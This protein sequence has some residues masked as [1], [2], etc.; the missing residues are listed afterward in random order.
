[1]DDEDVV[2]YVIKSGYRLLFVVCRCTISEY[3]V[4]GLWIFLSLNRF[5]FRVVDIFLCRS[6]KDKRICCVYHLLSG[7]VSKFPHCIRHAKNERTQVYY[8]SVSDLGK[9]KTVHGILYARLMYGERETKFS[10]PY[11]P[12]AKADDFRKRRAVASCIRG[13]HIIIIIREE[14]EYSNV[15]YSIRNSL[16]IFLSQSECTFFFFAS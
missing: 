9:K 7:I 13:R 6:S 15:L 14:R 11:S 3:K 1:M 2:N 5:H 4:G 12:E 8:V 16:H 10:S